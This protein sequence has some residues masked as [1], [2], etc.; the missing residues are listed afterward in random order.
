LVVVNVIC[1]SVIEA[2]L[3][4]SSIAVDELAR[5]VVERHLTPVTLYL[6]VPSLL[7][8]VVWTR[9]SC[10]DQFL[11]RGRERQV[12][13]FQT[14]CL[15]SQANCVGN[16][17]GRGRSCRESRPLEFPEILDDTLRK[18]FNPQIVLSGKTTGCSQRK[19]IGLPEKFVR[20]CVKGGALF[21]GRLVRFRISEIGLEQGNCICP[22]VL[23]LALPTES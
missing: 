15:E 9:C 23:F 16:V 2:P 19:Q 13:E 7:A 3:I 5:C 8:D 18:V 12:G 17:T 1:G 20:R 22:A 6:A 21:L 10:V 14:F 4:V 11:D